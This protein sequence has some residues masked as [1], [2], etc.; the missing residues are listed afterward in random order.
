MGMIKD[1]K[2]FKRTKEQTHPTNPTGNINQQTSHFN[3]D[4]T[5]IKKQQNKK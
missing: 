5:S 2:K 1:R 4:D 3:I